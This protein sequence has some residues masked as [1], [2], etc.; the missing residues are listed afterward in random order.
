MNQDIRWVQRFGNYRKA[1]EQLK[2]AV[3]LSKQRALSELEAQGLIQSF[4]YTHELAWN[5]LKDLLQDRG[6][7]GIYG[8]K[9]ATRESFKVGLIGNGETWMNM[10]QSRNRSSHT[11]NER[12]AREIVDDIV[13]HYYP[14]F[15]ALEQS[16]GTMQARE[17]GQP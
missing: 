17:S 5:T 13:N 2:R 3:E 4:E 15:T 9:D 8:S 10:I 1:L 14:E 6:N 16:L 12:T 11:H 7:I